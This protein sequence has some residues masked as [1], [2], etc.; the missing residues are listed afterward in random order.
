MS[1]NSSIHAGTKPWC[2]DLSTMG[3]RFHCSELEPVLPIR[4]TSVLKLIASK[5]THHDI[6]RA[7]DLPIWSSHLRS[8]ILVVIITCL[9]TSR[10]SPISNVHEVVRSSEVHLTKFGSTSNAQLTGLRTRLPCLRICGIR[11]GDHSTIKL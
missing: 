8:L 5:T 1:N 9:L 4:C 3:S 11:I 6:G 7:L 10:R 2:F